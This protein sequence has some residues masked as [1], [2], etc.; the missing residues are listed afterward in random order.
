MC[1]F[2]FGFSFIRFL[3]SSEESSIPHIYFILLFISFLQF[4]LSF[5]PWVWWN[6]NKRGRMW[7]SIQLFLC[8]FFFRLPYLWHM[9]SACWHAH[10]CRMPM[11]TLLSTS[12]IHLYITILNLYIY[13]DP[14][15]YGCVHDFNNFFRI[16]LKLNYC[17]IFCFVNGRVAGFRVRKT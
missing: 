2:H 4:L 13:V 15:L 3:F 5:P 6:V 16:R 11:H 12:S 10:P 7:L 9:L 8:T 14:Y 1:S 17:M